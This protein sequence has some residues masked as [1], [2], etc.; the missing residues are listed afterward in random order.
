MSYKNHKGFTLT[1]VVISLFILT[2]V[3]V[4]AVGVAVVGKY[5]ASRAKHRVQDI[6]VAQNTLEQMRR[7]PFSNL[8]SYAAPA[9]AGLTGLVTIDTKGIFNNPTN[10]LAKSVLCVMVH[11]EV[12]SPGT[13]TGSPWRSRRMTV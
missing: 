4:S 10:P 5:A 11:S 13:I 12:P 3:W 7:E 9:P 2:I 6:Y 8:E 1:E